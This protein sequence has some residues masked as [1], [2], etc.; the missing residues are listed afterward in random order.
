MAM[1]TGRMDPIP[2]IR[3]AGKVIALGN[4]GAN[5][6]LSPEIYTEEKPGTPEEIKRY[7]KSF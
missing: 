7:R 2:N 5:I 6:C 3:A 4:D 1:R